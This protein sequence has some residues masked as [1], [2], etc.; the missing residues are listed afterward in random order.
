MQWSLGRL[1]SSAVRSLEVHVQLSTVPIHQ[2]ANAHTLVVQRASPRC[3][4]GT[5][6]RLIEQ[7]GN[8]P[9]NAL[10]EGLPLLQTAR[11]HSVLVS[12]AAFAT[13]ATSAPNLRTLEFDLLLDGPDLRQAF[14]CLASLQN[15]TDLSL[16]VFFWALTDANVQIIG[17]LP[18]LS[19]LRLSACVRSD[20]FPAYITH[21]GISAQ[22]WPPGSFAALR[23]LVLRTCKIDTDAVRHLSQLRSIKLVA[24]RFTNG[25]FKMDADLPD[26][27]S[28]TLV[29]MK[30][31]RGRGEVPRTKLVA[32]HLDSVYMPLIL[33]ALPTWPGLKALCLH[34]CWELSDSDLGI[35]ADA[36]PHL[37]ELWISDNDV[38]TEQGVRRLTPLKLRFLAIDG[39][40]I[41]GRDIAC[42]LPQFTHLT[43]LR[44]TEPQDLLTQT[45]VRETATAMACALQFV[46]F[47]DSVDFGSFA[48]AA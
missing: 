47:Y 48:D 26:V 32:L 12:S 2:F 35:L 1:V 45:I 36:L 25:F 23:H 8:V 17:T 41:T 39:C 27:N 24:L 19:S 13:L 46:S 44:L 10:A 29:T 37:Q 22:A 14:A 42:V 15:L 11:L 38:I 16:K 31:E 40:G 30:V 3:Q 9:A 28:A 33:R 4:L 6:R 20:E 18:L 7:N 34:N 21:K 43:T 5:R